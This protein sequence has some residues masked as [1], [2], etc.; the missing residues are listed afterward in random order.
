MPKEFEFQKQ[1]P[2]DPGPGPL[3]CAALAPAAVRRGRLETP[4]DPGLSVGA[5]K[6][7]LG[8][9]AL[10]NVRLETFRFYI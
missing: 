4:G 10:P 9:E 5:W 7:Q 2:E 8:R 1:P 6:G 3:L